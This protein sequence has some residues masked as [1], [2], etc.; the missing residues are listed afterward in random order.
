MRGL[1]PRIH[2]LGKRIRAKTRWRYREDAMD[3]RV[4][5]A[6]DTCKCEALS[7]PTPSARKIIF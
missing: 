3:P 4:K 7:Q 5:P 6:G 2:P 1:D